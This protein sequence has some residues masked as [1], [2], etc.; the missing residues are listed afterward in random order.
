MGF[1][2]AM[3]RKGSGSS[4]VSRPMVTWRSCIAGG[5]VDRHGEADADE[6]LVAGGV[7]EAGHDSDHLT[8]SVQEGAAGVS[9]TDGGVELDEALDGAAVGEREVAFEA[10]DDA[11]R[12]RVDQ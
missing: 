6:V 2:V 10:G 9:G 8:L 4:C 5:R 3:T 12:K 7:G 11:R 1:W